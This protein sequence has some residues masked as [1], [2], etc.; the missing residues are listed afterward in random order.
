MIF[1]SYHIA[2]GLRAGVLGAVSL[3]MSWAYLKAEWILFFISLSIFFITIYNFFKFFSKRFEVIDDFFEAVKYR[4][5]SRNYLAEDKTKDIHRLYTGFNTV[6]QT[7]REMNSEKEV[8]YLYLQKILEMIDVGILAYDTGSGNTLWVNEAFQNMMDFPQFKNIKFVKSRT[9]DIYQKLFKNQY[10]QPTAVD[11]KIRNENLKVLT[12]QSV[13]K[14]ENNSCKLIV[15]HNIDDTVNKTESEAWKKLLSVMTH[16]IM[17]SIAPISSLANTLKSSVRKNI[18]DS[19]SELD[20]EDLDAGL[21][22]IE[23]RSEGLMKFA[24]T[25]RSL[26][27][28]TSLNK[29][30]I[31]LKELF[32]DIEQLMKT[33]TLNR[34]MLRFEVEDLKLEVEA[35]SYLLEQILIN[36]ILNAVEACEEI[37]KPEILV[38]AVK[39]PNGKIMIAVIDNGSGIPQE[40]QDQIFVPFFTTKKKGSGIGLS[41]SRQIMTLHGGKIQ[42]DNIQEKGA[43]VSLVF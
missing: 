3:V 17:N 12:S 24:K 15:I 18:D 25:Y 21:S 41:L 34:N 13:F 32:N 29:E 42:I 11:L 23:K 19:L 33:K 9:P 43:Q 27:K 37:D 7:V 39:K 8:Q 20:L 30:I 26:N 28:V 1:K 4:D 2:I 22:S 10:L 14:V 5:F 31:L 38:K 35:D 36:L 6:N 40:I 16:E